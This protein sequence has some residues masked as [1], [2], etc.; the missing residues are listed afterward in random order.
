VLQ[1]T[2]ALLVRVTIA[3]EMAISPTTAR[4]PKSQRKRSRPVASFADGNPASGG[5]LSNPFSI[6]TPRKNRRLLPPR[7][8]ADVPA[9]SGAVAT[10][11]DDAGTDE[12]LDPEV[13]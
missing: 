1:D 13:R 6:Y 2:P 12:T 8:N 9:G 11:S 3:R 10:S 5:P 7:H 4:R